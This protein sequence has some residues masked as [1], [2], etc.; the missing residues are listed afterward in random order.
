[1]DAEVVQATLGGSA[2]PWSIDRYLTAA[3]RDDAEH[4]CAFPAML[5]EIARADEP[6]RMAMAR[7]IDARARELTRRTPGAR[8]RGAPARA[9]DPG[10]VR[11]RPRVGARHA[12]PSR[13][14]RSARRLPEVGRLTAARR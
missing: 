14:R 2:V 11:R 9:G 10:A 1:M 5:S 7:A 4:G 12:R 3:H 8:P 6:T 13:Q